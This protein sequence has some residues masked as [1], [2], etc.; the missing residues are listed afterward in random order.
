VNEIIKKRNAL[1]KKMTAERG[2]LTAIQIEELSRKIISKLM[3]LEPI[4]K[5]RTIMSFSSIN[6]EVNLLHLLDKEI[7][8]GRTIVLPRVE[9]EGAMEAVEIKT[10]KQT[11]MGSFG[12]REPLGEPYEVQDIDV[13][14]VPGLVFDGNGYRL[15]Y[16]KGYYDRFLTR[17]RK[18]AFICGV[19][20]EFQ[21]VEN[22]FPH[23]NDIPVHWIVTDKSELGI[24]WNYF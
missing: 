4:R 2:K 21:V 12:I 1:R 3:E 17:L 8:G 9:K 11:K 13:V 10:W 5:A 22:I 14:L 20:Y 15:G 6:N 18:N 16:G 7:K 24:D 19:C 23:D